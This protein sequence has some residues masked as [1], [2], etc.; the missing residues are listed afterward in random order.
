VLSK[1]AWKMINS[2]NIETV[3]AEIAFAYLKARE[4]SPYGDDFPNF[5]DCLFRRFP[6]CPEAGA[7]I[8]VLRSW[9]GHRLDREI[10]ADVNL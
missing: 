3:P 6:A 1:G 7:M 4:S 10:L 2:S 5:E 9:P 8:R